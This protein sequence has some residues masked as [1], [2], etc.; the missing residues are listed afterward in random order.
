MFFFVSK[1][2]AWLFTPVIWIF[3]LLLYSLF[4]KVS[5]RKR[6]AL[7][8]AIAITYIFS[9]SFILDEFMRAWEVDAKKYNELQTYDCAI[10]MGG[11]LN[12]DSDFDRLQF[13]RASDRLWQALELYKMGK[14][15]K[16]LFVGGSGSIEYADIKEAPLLKRY[17]QVLNVPDSILLFEGESR[18]SHE[19][20]VNAKPVLQ[21]N[22]PNGKF[23]LITSAFHMR[24]SVA[25]FKKQGIEVTSYSADRYSGPRKFQWDHVFIPS[26]ETLMGWNTLIHEWIGYLTYKIA[27][28]C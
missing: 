3:G 16:I 4:S 10:V 22:F 11:V 18:N 8:A 28:Y 19:N 21:K 13:N 14:V 25:C 26:A 15:K 24:R 1:I 17:L 12:Y 5:V 23:L 9:N 6:K 2:I 20:A 7:I 27:G